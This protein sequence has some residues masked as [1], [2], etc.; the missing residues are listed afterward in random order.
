VQTPKWA[1]LAVVMAAV[2]VIGAFVACSDFTPPGVASSSALVVKPKTAHLNVGGTMQLTVT[3]SSG[4]V[5]W[6]T[7]DEAVATVSFGKVTAVA[8]GTATIRA[9]SGTNEATTRVTVTRAAAIALSST[10]VTFNGLPAAALPDSQTVDVTNSGEDPLTG[11]QLGDVVYGTGAT[12]W[13]TAQLT[14]S[15][16]PAKLVLRPNTSTLAPGSYTATVSIASPSLTIGP[17][18]VAVRFTLTRPAGIALGSTGATFSVQQ[19]SALPAQQSIAITNAGD[20]ALEG[21]AVGTIVY[22]SGA[23]NWLDA[24]VTPSVAPAS[25][26][27]RPNT[28]ALAP[29]DYSATVPVTSTVAGV[30]PGS[31]TVTYHV[32]AAPTPPS[33]VLS[34]QSVS[35]SAATGDPLPAQTSV[36][37][38]DGGQQPLTGLTVTT[39]Y[40]T[41]QPTNWL[42]VSTGGSSAPTTVVLRPNTTGLATGTYTA[43]VTVASPV[44]SNQSVALN[45]SYTLIRPASIVL[46]ATTATFSAQQGTAA[47]SQQ[48]IAIT[49]GGDAPLTGLAAGTPSYSSGASG[50]L[51]ASV[52]STS[53]PASLL[54]Q[55][56]VTSLA[57]GDYSA[58]V[59]VTSSVAGVAPQTV[60]VTYHVTAAPTPPVIVL[61]TSTL[62]FTAT[63]GDAT[64]LPAQLPVSVSNGGQAALTGV[65]VTTAYTA[66]QTPGWLTVTPSGSTAPLSIGVQP[67]TVGLAAGTYTAT[68]S[69]SSSVATNTPQT[70]A[71]TYKVIRPA[72]IVLAATTATFNAQQNGAA[73]LQQSIGITNGGDAAL[74]GLSV[75]TPSY[76]S[77][78]SGW[79]VA[80]VSP[81]AAPAN[82]FLQ[83]NTTALAPGDYTVTIPVTSSVPNVASQTVTVTYHVTAPPPVIVVNPTSAT[84]TAGRNFGTLPA[85]TQIAITSTGSGS[86]SGLSAASIT[87]GAGASNWLGTSFVGGVTTAPTTLNVQPNTTSLAAGVYSATI[88]LS[89]TTTGVVTKDI[90]VTYVV[91]DL[92]LSQTSIQFTT[93]SSTAPAAQVVNVSNGGSGSIS[94][95]TASVTLLTGRADGSYAWLQASI[96][97][98]VPQSPSAASLTLTPARADSLG[99]FTARVTVSAPNMI[100]K[101]V[102][103]SYR[104]QATMA[105]DIF[106]ILHDS[107]TPTFTCRACHSSATTGNFSIDFSTAAAAYSSLLT[108]ASTPG[109][110]YIVSGDSAASNLYKIL[111][112]TPPTGYNAMPSTSCTTNQAACMNTQLR[113]R[114]YI[115][116]VQGALQNP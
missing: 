36:N 1:G 81:S 18:V 106:P 103:V 95:V 38:T 67:N 101:T 92:V 11:L 53:A 19:A 5:V 25:L 49:N 15:N 116:I 113:T 85:I 46:G 87:Y 70:I 2:G 30:A 93:T 21:L 14:Q 40:A 75:G 51:A 45:V 98:T 32:T 64:T 55:P 114:I 105:L 90:P 28:S 7:S 71:V 108:P 52:S 56:T 99:D 104:R 88:H 41:G 89:S 13:L 102:N 78:A 3:G 37:V 12:G 20:A 112:G 97:G 60:T 47:P 74:T 109:H 111:N 23:S 4:A 17:Q 66:G 24:S 9:V 110:T 16:A 76:S 63:S 29:G 50:W 91:N 62:S 94:G 44:A 96:A 42:T 59:A 58:T 86:V 79:L 43:T 22:S 8:S 34:Q 65:S 80:S 54:L 33:I 82:L 84:F 73:P 115:W 68:V 39:S 107:V 48:P 26:L 27:L 31:V 61:S 10:N 100:S 69:V 6:S 35:F 72:S 77:G 83:P 57:V